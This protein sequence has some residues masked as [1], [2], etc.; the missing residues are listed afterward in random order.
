VDVT[1]DDDLF[2]SG[3]AEV[4]VSTGLSVNFLA[5]RGSNEF[6]LEAGVRDDDY[7]FIDRDR[8]SRGVSLSFTRQVR[9]GLMLA[10]SLSYS[11]ED[12]TSTGQEDDLLIGQLS[13]NWTLSRR[14]E[15]ALSLSYQERNSNAATAE[16]E[17]WV[18]GV[19]LAYQILQ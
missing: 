3:L 12:F 13:A 8:E 7:E 16:Y 14:L 17:E 19:S 18:G 10:S 4:F 9:E 5:Q 11:E 1:T 15:L 2:E 6:T